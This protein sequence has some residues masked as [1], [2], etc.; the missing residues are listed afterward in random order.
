MHIFYI[1]LHWSPRANA[2][3]NS[4]TL[5]FRNAGSYVAPQ[6]CFFS[7]KAI[8]IFYKWHACYFLLVACGHSYAFA[9]IHTPVVGPRRVHNGSLRSHEDSL[10]DIF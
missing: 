9:L 3:V 8:Q 4:L 1:L 2:E 7:P 10:S 6:Y 5:W